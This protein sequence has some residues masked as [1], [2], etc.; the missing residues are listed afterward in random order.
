[1]A[2]LLVEL[3]EQFLPQV[4][5]VL[6]HPQS[7][8]LRQAYLHTPLAAAEEAEVVVVTLQVTPVQLVAQV[9]LLMEH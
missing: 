5:L 2:V 7:I 1:L 9:A 4:T 3:E 6:L 8:Y